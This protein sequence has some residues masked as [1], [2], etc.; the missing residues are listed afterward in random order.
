MG[1]FCP[2]KEKAMLKSTIFSAAPKRAVLMAGATAA[3]ALAALGFSSGAQA[4]SDVSFSIGVG[5]PGV[6]VG[7]T[8]AYPVYRQPVYVQPQP[9]YMQP[10]PVYVQPRPVYMQPQPIYVQPR[11]VYVQQAPVYVGPAPIY[12]RGGYRGH[13]HG[14]GHGR[15]EFQ[16]RGYYR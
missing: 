13:G 14:Y 5:I 16:G 4:R 3:L 6:Q 8:N 7:V 2:F 11:P 12:Y 15:P 9:V 10:Q 1:T